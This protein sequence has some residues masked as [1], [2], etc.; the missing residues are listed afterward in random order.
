MHRIQVTLDNRI[1]ETVMSE[2]NLT[3]NNLSAVCKFKLEEVIF[4]SSFI[5]SFNIVPQA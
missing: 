5:F 3:E 4:C 1:L 2:N